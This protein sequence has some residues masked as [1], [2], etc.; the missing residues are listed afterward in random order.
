MKSADRRQMVALAVPVVVA[1]LAGNPAL[2]QSNSDWFS[3]S[4][5]GL[6]KSSHRTTPPRVVKLAARYRVPRLNGGEVEWDDSFDATTVRRARPQYNTSVYESPGM[7]GDLPPLFSGGVASRLA[8]STPVL[9]M[10]TVNAMRTAIA[11]YEY[12]VN[13]G[14]WKTIP[15]GKSLRVGSRSRRVA[16]LRARLAATGDLR[17]NSGNSI[18]YDSYVARAVK[19]FQYRNGLLATGVVNRRTLKALNVS[20]SARLTQLRLN[21]DRISELAA[22]VKDTFIMVNIPAAELEAVERGVVRSRHRIVVGKP[23]RPSPLVTSRVTQVNFYPYWHVPESIV[24]KD[25]V[26]KLQT[27]P[28]YLDRMKLRVYRTWGGEEIDPK[29]IDWRSPEALTYKFRQDPGPGNALGFVRINIPNAHAVYMHDTPAKSL[30]NREYRA[31]S[32]GCVRIQNVQDLLGW[33]LKGEPDWTPSRINTV[34]RAGESVDVNLKKT[35]PVTW[36]YI[37]AWTTPKGI[38][39]FRR[40]LYN[41]DGVGRLAANY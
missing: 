31:Q 29:T 11:R 19:A 13:R 28:G 18:A 14:G 9:S 17:Q 22:R 1:C 20:A 33:I 3:A 10:E 34:I 30:F 16:L 36:V 2:A 26:P 27:D 21:V 40:D 4:S 7:S 23:E 41:R 6:V 32:S 8:T 5:N 39:Q 35:I 38:V 12:I 25:L 37:T 24:R 15:G